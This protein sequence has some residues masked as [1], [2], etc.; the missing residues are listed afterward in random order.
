M[1]NRRRFVYGLLS[2]GVLGRSLP[3]RANA[4]QRATLPSLQGPLSREVFLA[5]RQETFTAVIDGRRVP[6]VLVSVSDAAG[7]GDP[8]QF[9]VV[10]RGPRD[11]PP[12]D[13]VCLFNHPT[14]GGT[15]L[16]VQATGTDDRAGYYKAPFNLSS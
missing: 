10:F 5:L 16:Y 12:M 11:L 6:L 14:A 7:G 2:V 8:R 13:R 4:A 1:L 3:G 15:P 9:T